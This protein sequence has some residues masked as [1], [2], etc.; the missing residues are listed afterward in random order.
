MIERGEPRV[1][2]Y[3]TIAGNDFVAAECTALVGLEP[4]EAGNRGETPGGRRSPLPWGLWRVAVDRRTSSFE[5]PIAELLAILAP[6]ATGL[7]QVVS[8]AGVSAS[9]E[10]V[11]DIFEETLAIE[12]TNETVSAIG[13]LGAGLSLD[14]IDH[15]AR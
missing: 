14:V 6:H 9:V 8:R 11:V 3:F 13:K 2:A 4:T 1:R 7:A 15:R 12:L 10:C 5:G